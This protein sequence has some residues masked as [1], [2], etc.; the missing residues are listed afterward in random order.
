MLRTWHERHGES[1][2]I[3]GGCGAKARDRRAPEKTR[4]SAERQRPLHLSRSSRLRLP[5]QESRARPTGN[6]AELTEFFRKNLR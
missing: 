1:T 6:G 2:P 5:L 4:V 3:S